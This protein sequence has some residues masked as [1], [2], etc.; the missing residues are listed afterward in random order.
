[1][2]AELRGYVNYSDAW[3]YLSEWLHGVVED[4]PDERRPLIAKV[5]LRSSALLIL[6]RFRVAFD[7]VMFNTAEPL[8]P[9][10]A[11]DSDDD[12]SDDDDSDA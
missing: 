6:D 9:P 7:N 2:Y 3:K 12:D 11:Q 10:P 8:P 1:M 5:P 4:Q